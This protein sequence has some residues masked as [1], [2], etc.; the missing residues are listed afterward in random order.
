MP[1]PPPKQLSGASERLISRHTAPQLRRQPWPHLDPTHLLPFVQSGRT[2]HRCVTVDDGVHHNSSPIS[3]A[4]SQQWQQ[5]ESPPDFPHLGYYLCSKRRYQR[6]HK[7]HHGGLAKQWGRYKG[8][9]TGKS[10]P[11]SVR[12]SGEWRGVGR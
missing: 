1:R 12:Q 9:S 10:H 11:R 4:S 5:L 6:L 7:N 3:Y 8:I 2:C